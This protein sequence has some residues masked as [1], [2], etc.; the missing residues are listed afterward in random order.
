MTNMP[1][2]KLAREAQMA[3]APVAMVTDYDCWHPHEADV[4][5]DL[6][7]RNL[8]ENSARAQ[9]IIAEA[10][11]SLGRELPVSQAHTALAQALVTRPED[12]PQPRREALAPF[13][14]AP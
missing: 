5:A 6:A 11:G 2:A 12:M 1:E 13:L 4:S 10:V 9:R 14:A 7:L 3:Y 8:M